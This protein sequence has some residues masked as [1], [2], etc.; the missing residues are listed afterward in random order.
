MPGTRF[1]QPDGE[2]P[3]GNEQVEAPAPTR[4]PTQAEA[5]PTPSPPV[6]PP[7]EEAPAEEQ[8]VEE[9]TV[10][11]EEW[12]PHQ[13]SDWVDWWDHDPAEPGEV[14]D[15]VMEKLRAE[16]DEKYAKYPKDKSGELP[17]DVREA[18]EAEKAA[19]GQRAAPEQGQPVSTEP[20]P[21]QPK[22]QQSPTP[23]KPPPTR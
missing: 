6:Q 16:A 1:R 2:P 19:Y 17:P 21:Q 8:A 13:R 10:P 22:Q 14:P 12:L 23:S 9:Q 5:P 3:S 15:D 4:A 11:V 7:E 20:P 18:F